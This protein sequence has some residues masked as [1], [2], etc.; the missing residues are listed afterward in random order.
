MK[1]SHKFA[2]TWTVKE[3][4]VDEYVKMHLNP[5]PE[6]LEEHRKAG[7]KNYSIFQNGNQFFY[8]FECDDVN[9]AFDYIAKS[10]VCNK[11][12]AITSKMVEGSFDFN[13]EEP[14]KPLREIFYLE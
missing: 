11:W 2:W 14:I 1:N 8:C 12:N 5:W 9:A 10:E 3:E 7:I 13:K 4:H 6:I